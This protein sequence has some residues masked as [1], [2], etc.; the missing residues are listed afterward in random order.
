M[1]IKTMPNEISLLCKSCGHE[2][3]ERIELP[4]EVGAAI[5]RIRGW[6]YCPKCGV[7]DAVFQACQ[8]RGGLKNEKE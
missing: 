2:W 8:N 6:G 3:T 1:E 7:Q 4:M 5:A